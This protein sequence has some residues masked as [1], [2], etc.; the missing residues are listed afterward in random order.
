MRFLTTYTEYV[1]RLN[2]QWS[3]LHLFSPGSFTLCCVLL[4]AFVRLSVDFGKHP[5]A[6][7]RLQR[8][9]IQVARTV[10]DLPTAKQMDD[11]IKTELGRCQTGMAAWGG[12]SAKAL[13]SILACITCLDLS[14]IA[15]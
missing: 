1:E 2:K 13:I 10:C 12:W 14:A 15:Q 8:T 6:R 11:P 9:R 4:G 5:H 7:C 3:I